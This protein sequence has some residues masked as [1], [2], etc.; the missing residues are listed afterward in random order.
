MGGFI[1][2]VNQ[3]PFQPDWNNGVDLRRKLGLILRAK[4]PNNGSKSI[5]FRGLRILKVFIPSV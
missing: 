2:N 1:L 5:V 4:L 3:L